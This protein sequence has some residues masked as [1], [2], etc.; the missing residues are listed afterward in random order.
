MTRPP[1]RG[2][3]TLLAVALPPLAFV[4]LYSTRGLRVV[5]LSLV[6]PRSR[7]AAAAAL[8]TLLLGFLN[9]RTYRLGDWE[10]T[11]TL[12]ERDVA[13]DPAYGGGYSLLA[14]DHSRQGRFDE[15]EARIAPLLN[16][17][18]RFDGTASYLNWLALVHVELGDRAPTRLHLMIAR[19]QAHLNQLGASL[20]TLLLAEQL[21]AGDPEALQQI[22]TVRTQLQWLPAT[23]R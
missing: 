4:L 6:E 3:G 1:A 17:D 20:S 2:L 12:F 13:R 22:Q 11:Q 5:L 14:A 15:A 21:A 7:D 23:R 10:S 16:P 18:R 8:A 19:H 9:Q